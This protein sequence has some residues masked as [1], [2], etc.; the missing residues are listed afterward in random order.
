MERGKG[1]VGEGCGKEFGKKKETTHA[2]IEPAS[3]I[4][5]RIVEMTMQA[6]MTAEARRS[7]MG[8]YSFVTW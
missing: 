1:E 7:A 8:G 6:A 5:P 2:T 3:A 4:T